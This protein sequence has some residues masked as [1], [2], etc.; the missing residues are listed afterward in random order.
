MVLTY[1]MGLLFRTRFRL[2][3]NELKLSGHVEDYK[4]TKSLG[5]SYFAVKASR[6]VHRSLHKQIKN[7]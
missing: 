6:S 4:E 2:I 7:F 1:T 3:L 5:T